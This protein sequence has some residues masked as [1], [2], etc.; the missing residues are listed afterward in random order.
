VTPGRVLD[1][2]GVA[3][4]VRSEDALL[5]ELVARRL[6][7]FPAAESSDDAVRLELRAGGAHLVERPDGPVRP[8]YEPETGEVLYAEEDDVLYVDYG[9]VRARVEATAGSA[10]VSVLEP[11]DEVAWAA[12]RPLVTLPL[13]E[14]LKRRG[15]FGVHAGGVALEGRGVVLAGTSGAGKTTLTLALALAGFDLL[16]D[17]ML[18]LRAEDGEPAML[19][20]PDELDVSETTASFFPEL[21]ARLRPDAL[22]GAVKRQLDPA[23]LE[24]DLVAEAR[25]A[26][27]LFPRIGTGGPSTLEPLSFDEALLELAPNVLL[28]EA[29]SSQRHLE[30]LGSLLRA[31]RSF[32]LSTGR[33]FDQTAALIRQLLE[34]Q[35]LADRRGLRARS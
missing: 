2:H 25:P 10:L 13:L 28:T 29:S 5:A 3:V 20:F 34:E 26:L 22:P 19:A 1:V 27:V 8:V 12:T 32:R 31:G 24:A 16:G 23:A 7:F 9:R 21:K 11:V 33:D 14:L 17:D 6:A 4:D 18:F 35:G 15:V 30:T